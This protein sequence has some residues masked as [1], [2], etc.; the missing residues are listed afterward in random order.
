MMVP[1]L[2]AQLGSLNSTH[3]P[4]ALGREAARRK[5]REFAIESGEGYR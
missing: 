4:Y 1:L 2:R 3:M 5:G